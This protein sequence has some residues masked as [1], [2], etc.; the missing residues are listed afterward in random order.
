M[1]KTKI[2]PRYGGAIRIG[3]Q[4]EHEARV[5][6]F[7]LSE[8]RKAFGEGRAELLHRRVGDEAA[9][10]VPTAMEGD[11]LL[12]VVS[13]TDTA[14][15]GTG[16]VELRF[17]AGE[18]LAKSRTWSTRVRKSLSVGAE[19]PEEAKSW[20][21]TLAE[22]KNSVLMWLSEARAFLDELKGKLERGE[23]NGGKGDPGAKGDK[24]DPGEQTYIENPYND[25]EIKGEVTQLREAVAK[26]AT[27]PENPVVGQWGRV[28][29][30]DENGQP[31]WET[32][33]LPLASATEEGVV[34]PM[35]AGGTR[36]ENGALVVQPTDPSLI[37]GRVP[38]TIPAASLEANARRP[39]TGAILDYAIKAAMCD[40][41]GAEWTSTEKQSSRE[42]QGI[43][44]MSQEE[45][46]LIENP[47]GICI[48]T[49][50][51]T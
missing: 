47:T 4:G 18:T 3:K 19:P 33:A 44:V 50:E 29:S 1:R 24:G 41:K 51:T 7:D 27:N 36:I 15:A 22:L 5:V 14:R 46:D 2:S 30:I 6:E 17:Y 13:A 21:D 25:S 34:K 31:V 43:Y 9:Y 23:L 37:D 40:G 28:A 39:I 10:P 42:R 11:K 32:A 38:K 26:K 35:S 8:Y 48:I 12:W 16:E 20:F 49:E 45:Y